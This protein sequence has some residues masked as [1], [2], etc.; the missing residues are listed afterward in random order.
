MIVILDNKTFKSKTCKKD[1]DVRCAEMITWKGY[2]LPD[3]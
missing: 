2:N 3:F 1:S